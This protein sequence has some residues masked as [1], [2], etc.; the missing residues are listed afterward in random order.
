MSV[1]EHIGSAATSGTDT[2]AP[3]LHERRINWSQVGDHAILIAGSLLMMAPVIIAFFTSTHDAVTVHRE[4]LQLL[5]GGEFAETY[6]TVLF[7]GTGFTGEVNGMTMMMNSLI[8]GFGFAVGKIV[9]SMMAAYAI[10]YFRFPFATLAF[11]MIFTT[12][13]LPL[14]VRILPSYEIVQ[15]WD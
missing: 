3:V 8:L 10:V 9:I 7:Q 4:G 1:S 14:E 11:W 2:A 12:L 13:L 6:G 5:P 15:R